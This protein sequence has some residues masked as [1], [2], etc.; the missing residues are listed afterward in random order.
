MEEAIAG[1]LLV[2]A[3]RLSAGSAAVGS[4]S[5]LRHFLLSQGL[6]CDTDVT[7][8]YLLHCLTEP[9]DIWVVHMA[10]Q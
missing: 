6:L 10:Q 4:G 2:A 8:I 5:G 1:W 9:G 3:L 7:P